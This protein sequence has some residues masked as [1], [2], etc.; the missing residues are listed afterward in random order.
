MTDFFDG[1][2]VFMAVA[3][4]L[5]FRR[6][7]E[8]LGVTRPAVSQAVARLEA[9]VGVPL[10]Q[11]TT[12]T[13][14][15]TVAGE[16]LFASLAPARATLVETLTAIGDEQG[17]PRGTIR[18]VVSSIAESVMRGESLARFIER[19]PGIALDVFVTDDEFD[20]FREGYDAGVRLGEVIEADMIAV[21]VSRPQRQIAVAAPHY[22]ARRGTPAHPRELPEFD[23]IGW[24]P[25][26]DTAPYRWEFA[27]SGRPFDVA[28]QP[29]TTTNDM[30]VM[31]HTA[32]AGAGITFGMAETFAPWLARGEL[33]T[34][35]DA[36][37]P[38]IPG[39]YLYFPGGNKVSAKL[40]ALIDCLRLPASA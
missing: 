20:I 34:V 40:R 17:E 31:I 28:V 15:L 36:F 33:V 12:R 3:E 30:R 35:L 2:D 5:S 7:G 37:C 16:R 39:F 14:R 10:F 24:R 29:R 19:H 21:P 6:A 18:L 13:V 9:R 11:R 27:E 32:V 26:P 23:C 4:T 38:V 1:M 8:R 22:C 25:A